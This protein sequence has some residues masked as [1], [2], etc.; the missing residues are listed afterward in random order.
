MAQQ[1]VELKRKMDSERAAVA[2]AKRQVEMERDVVRQQQANNW[3]ETVRV[4]A[5]K[6]NLDHDKAMVL[7]DKEM[8]QR[9]EMKLE[10]LENQRRLNR[11]VSSEIL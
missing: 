1:M 9:R 10:E 8:N 2:A 6:A 7:R 3:L 4:E 5:E 11:F